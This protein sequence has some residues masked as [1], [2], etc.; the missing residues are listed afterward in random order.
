M[1]TSII[2]GLAISIYLPLT[3]SLSVEDLTVNAFDLVQRIS[4]EKVIVISIK[5]TRKMDD[6]SNFESLQDSNLTNNIVGEMVS[7]SK[8]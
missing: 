1:N 8:S 6:T 5:I 4:V 3:S 7:L 2:D